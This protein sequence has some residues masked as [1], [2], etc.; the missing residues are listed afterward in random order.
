[1]HQGNEILTL[2]GTTNQE[3]LKQ[4]IKASEIMLSS[5]ELE[6]LSKNFPEGTFAGTRYA[7]PQMR[8]VVN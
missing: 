3:R 2:F 4:N 5:S 8:L 6:F 7:E 1:M